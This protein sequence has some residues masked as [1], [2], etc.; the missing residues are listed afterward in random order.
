MLQ[1]PTWLKVTNFL[2]F[3][4]VIMPQ[5]WIDGRVDCRTIFH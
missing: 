2:E 3:L 1:N 5:S 4:M